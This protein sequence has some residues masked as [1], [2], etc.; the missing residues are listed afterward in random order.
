MAVAAWHAL[1]EKPDAR[2]SSAGIAAQNGAR[3]E[4]HAVAVAREWNYDLRSHAAR[5]IDAEMMHDSDLVCTMTQAGADSLRENYPAFVE[6]TRVLGEF[7]PG[8]LRARDIDDPFG[9]SLEEYGRCATQICSAIRGLAATLAG[10]K[11]SG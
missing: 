11:I 3:A 7:A 6:K 1:E 9:G 8:E 2:V 10:G 5:Q 4:R